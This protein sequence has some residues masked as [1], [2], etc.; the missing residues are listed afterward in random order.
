MKYLT[1]TLASVVMLSAT[2]AAYAEASANVA[3]S[4]NYMFRGISQTGED[5][6]EPAISGGFDFGH[7]SGLYIGTWASN[8]ELA[9][10]DGDNDVANME[11]DI[12]G[13]YAGEMGGLSYDVGLLYFYYPGT[14]K[15]DFFEY[16]G[17]L[18]TSVGSADVGLSINIS[19]DYYAESGDSYYVNASASMPLSDSFGVNASVGYQSIDEENTF[20]T[21][22]Y[23]DWK[24]GLTT[25]AMG[26]DLELAWIDT[27]LSNSDC[28]GGT[29][30]CDGRAVFTA[31]KS[32]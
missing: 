27:D 26:L 14:D 13:G 15:L 19:P 2:G 3:L 10:A 29:D 11:M 24:L 28:F 9:D 17:S 16:Y 25:S 21:P 7:E 5:A 4:S 30:F 22:D 31:S 23:Y 32:F 1:H 20:G 6:I 8:V 18:G 12:Y